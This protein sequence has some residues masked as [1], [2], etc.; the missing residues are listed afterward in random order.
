MLNRTGVA[1]VNITCIYDYLDSHGIQQSKNGFLYLMIMIQLSS[2]NFENCIKITELYRKVG[3]IHGVSGVSVER[4][5]R[6]AIGD[7]GLT[8]K[9]FILKATYDLVMKK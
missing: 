8:S 2:E 6:Y 7:Q 5:I 4:A 3:K 1:M 9:E